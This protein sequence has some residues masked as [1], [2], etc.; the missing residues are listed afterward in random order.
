MMRTRNLVAALVILIGVAFAIE[1]LFFMEEC[2]CLKCLN[3]D[4]TTSPCVCET[5]AN[6]YGRELTAFL[7]NKSDVKTT[8]VKSNQRPQVACK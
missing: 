3:A 5:T 2:T 6:K 8:D 7:S 4:M 1:Y